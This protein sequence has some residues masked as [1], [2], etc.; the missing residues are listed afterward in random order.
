M[1][2]LRRNLA[3]ISAEAWEQI[4]DQAKAGLISLLSA[5]KIVDVEGPKGWDFAGIP[6]GRMKLVET[7]KDKQFC[8]GIRETLPIVE[9]RISFSLNIWEL[10][11]ATR[12]AEDIE[13]DNLVEAVKKIAFFEE[14]ALYYGLKDAK[15]EGLLTANKESLTFPKEPSKWLAA[16]TEGVLKMKDNAIEG[17]Y[18]LVLPPS[19]WKTVNYFAECYPL[20]PQIED[21]LQGEIIL[22][23]FIDSGLLVSTR[24]G[25]F[26]M[27]LGTDFSIG[28]EHHTNKE[29]TLFLTESFTLQILEPKATMKIQIK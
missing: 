24:G 22:S 21:V 9:P 29:V 27:V 15:I 14:K 4:E 1:N 8:Y 26:K 20:F 5:R 6:T 18:A 23:N 11:N 2:N 3:P 19:V 12:G 10:D 13:L 25:D 28:Y 16:I 17:P 7:P